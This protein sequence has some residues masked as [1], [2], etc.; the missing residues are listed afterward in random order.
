MYFVIN[1]IPIHS[2][3]NFDVWFSLVVTEAVKEKDGGSGEPG[4]GGPGGEGDLGPRGTPLPL[5]SPTQQQA[6]GTPPLSV[7]HLHHLPGGG[8]GG[9]ADPQLPA[10]STFNKHPAA[11]A[12]Q[13]HV[14]SPATSADSTNA[15]NTPVG[16]WWRCCRFGRTPASLNV[17]HC[18]VQNEPFSICMTGWCVQWCQSTLIHISRSLQVMLLGG[19]G[20]FCPNPSSEQSATYQITVSETGRIF[21]CETRNRPQA[22]FCCVAT[23]VFLALSFI[24]ISL[25]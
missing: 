25:Q 14:T 3:Q 19:P 15:N 5:P 12:Q 18:G 21:R 4:G 7:D 6:N 9:G 8:G 10:M 23:V 24:F 11:H 2:A 20:S 1:R 22:N 16:E 17:V 13:G